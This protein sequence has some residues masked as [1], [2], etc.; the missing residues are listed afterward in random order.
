[1]KGV[2][3]LKELT[4]INTMAACLVPTRLAWEPVAARLRCIL[5]AD[6]RQRKKSKPSMFVSR[7][8]SQISHPLQN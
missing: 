6:V 7:S 1:M 8:A 3:H 5:D 2:D 4:D